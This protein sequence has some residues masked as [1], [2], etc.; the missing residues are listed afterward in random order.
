[1]TCFILDLK[2]VNVINLTFCLS[3]VEGNKALLLIEEPILLNFLIQ[4]RKEDLHFEKMLNKHIYGSTYQPQYHF[5]ME[6][7]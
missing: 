2:A 3:I 7:T 5:K 6:N 1:M 4:N